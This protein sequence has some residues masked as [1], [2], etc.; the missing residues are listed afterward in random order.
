MKNHADFTKAVIYS[1]GRLEYLMQ[2]EKYNPLDFTDA[3]TLR[4]LIDNMAP[5]SSSAAAPV[6]TFVNKTKTPKIALSKPK[7]AKKLKFDS[8]TSVS[9]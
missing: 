5:K 6:K 1:I 3:R 4:N 8:S 2:E 9:S 7:R